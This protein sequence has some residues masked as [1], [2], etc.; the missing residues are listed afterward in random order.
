M[1]IMRD[2]R[3]VMWRIIFL[4]KE[5][6]LYYILKILNM[7]FKNGGCWGDIV[8]DNNFCQN[9]L[10]GPDRSVQDE[11]Y[12]VKYVYQKYWFEADTL[13]IKNR[14]VSVYNESSITDLFAYDVDYELL[15]D[16][17][18]VDSGTLNISC[19]SGETTKFSVTYQM[20][21]NKAEGAEYFLNLKV[22]LREYTLWAKKR[23]YYCL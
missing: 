18:I 3:F 7:L 4:L 19:V 16:G 10:V 11:L 8:N 6:R 23:L 20:P 2:K 9:G 14:K 15:E 12:E 5:Y 22:V 13:D 1:Y 21:E 17:K